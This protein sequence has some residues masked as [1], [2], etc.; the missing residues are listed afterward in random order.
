MTADPLSACEERADGHQRIK[1]LLRLGNRIPSKRML[2]QL[3]HDFVVSI[4]YLSGYVEP[5]SMF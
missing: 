5:W 2:C 4:A 1:M 3:Y